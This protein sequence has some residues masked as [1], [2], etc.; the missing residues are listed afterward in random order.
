MR[1]LRMGH[2][3]FANN[4]EYSEMNKSQSEAQV[5]YFYVDWNTW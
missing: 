4:N 2:N 5:R 3:G 1:I